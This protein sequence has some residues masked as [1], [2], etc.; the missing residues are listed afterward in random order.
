M[1]CI[2]IPIGK[3]AVSPVRD[4]KDLYL[5]SLADTIPADYIITG[6]KDLLILQVHNQTNIIKYTDFLSTIA[7]E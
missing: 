4:V 6:D 2:H 7:K 3:K 1:Y 5:L